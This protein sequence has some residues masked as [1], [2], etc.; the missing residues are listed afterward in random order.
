NPNVGGVSNTLSSGDIVRGGAGQD[1]LFAQLV[2]EFVG[3][4]ATAT[5]DA[6]PIISSVEKIE[7]EVRDGDCGSNGGSYST[8]ASYGSNQNVYVD[9]KYITGHVRIGSKQSDG[10]LVIENLT[11]LANNGTTARNTEDI[12]ITMDHT[13][14]FNSDGDASDLFVFFDD[15]Y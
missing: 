12:T 1:S 14:N 7:F 6:Q 15:D 3:G 13:D 2:P 10:D 5:I 11:T 4:G 9:A 8:Y